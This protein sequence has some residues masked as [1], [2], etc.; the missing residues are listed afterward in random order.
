MT[1][2][3][4]TLTCSPD[5]MIVAARA[6]KYAATEMP[7]QDAIVIYGRNALD[8]VTFYVKRTKAGFSVRQIKSAENE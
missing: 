8:E 4:F 1:M 7:G 2:P 3:R 5:E 6:A